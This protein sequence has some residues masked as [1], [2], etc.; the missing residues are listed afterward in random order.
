[1]DEPLTHMSGIKWRLRLKRPWKRDSPR[2]LDLAKGD[3]P[4]RKRFRFFNSPRGG[5]QNVGCKIR[6]ECGST[7]CGT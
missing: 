2:E 1:M 6:A 7:C 5:V 4:N 3:R